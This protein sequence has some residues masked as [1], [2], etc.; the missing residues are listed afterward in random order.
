MQDAAAAIDGR[1]DQ[2]IGG[3]AVL[4]LNVI[5]RIP[6]FY[7]RVMPEEHVMFVH[8]PFG[9]FADSSTSTRHRIFLRPFDRLAVEWIL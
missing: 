2:S 8:S 4:G 6:R 7:V 5:N 1:V 3:A 9:G